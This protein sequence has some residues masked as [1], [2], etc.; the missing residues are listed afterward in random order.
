M[1]INAFN[2]SFKDQFVLSIPS[3]EFIPGKIYAVIGAN[4]SGKST[5][6]RILAK[7]I[8]PDNKEKLTDQD[9]L[10]IGY[11]PQK[12]YAFHMSTLK[13]ILLN[14]KDKKRAHYLME[15]LQ[16]DHLS[17]RS[18]YKLSGGETAKMALARLLM[19]KY[20]LLVLDEPT[21]SMD[22]ESSKVTEE[23]IKTYTGDNNCICIIITHSLSEARRISDYTFF[24]KE[25]SLI[26]Y[27]A[28]CDVLEN[29]QKEDTKQFLDFFGK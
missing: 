21:A 15:I 13:N 16:I 27:G 29:P 17:N 12:S 8:K 19:N 18:A 7:I 23:L 5:F 11:L 6:A 22:I 24:I 1:I 25:G 26:E 2:K 4:G 9:N 3:L 20:E 14:N 10:S 28:T